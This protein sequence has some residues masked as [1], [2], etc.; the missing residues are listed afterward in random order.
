M[1]YKA[2][3]KLLKT[4]GAEAHFNFKF[5]LTNEL[6]KC[7]AF[8][9]D[10][11]KEYVEAYERATAEAENMVGGIGLEEDSEQALAIAKQVEYVAGREGLGS[12]VCSEQTQASRPLWW[13][14]KSS[15]NL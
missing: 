11:E 13:R 7:N 2:L 10:R 1:D 8:F 12:C 5:C 9:V 14:E 3:K 15:V 6:R 4:V